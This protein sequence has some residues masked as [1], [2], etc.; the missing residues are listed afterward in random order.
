VRAI[1]LRRHGGPD[2]LVAETV[3][4]PVPGQGEA[5][6]RVR[7]VAVNRLD[8]LVRE[9]TGHAYRARLPLVPGYDVAGDIVA[10]GAGGAPV[11]SGDRVYVH[12]DYACGRCAACFA[13]DESLCPEYGL[14]GVDHDGGYAELVLAPVANLFALPDGLDH[15]TAAAGGSVSLT[16]HHMLFARGGLQAGETVLV[17]AS[18]S[19]VG[20]A[21][22]QLA[23]W[24]GARVLAT[25][26]SEAKRRSALAA[27]AEAAIDYGTPGWSD[28]VRAATGGRGADLVIDHTGADY[29]E[30]VVRALAPRGRV[31]VCGATSG[32]AAGVDL[33]D[34]FARQISIIGSSDGT[35]AELLAVLELLA[36]GVLRPAI[37][38][39]L[40]LEAAA[41]AQR[42]LAARDHDGRILLIPAP[43]RA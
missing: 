40:P 20:G 31:V 25:A 15:E 32:A 2:A 22:L 11:R 21:A 16:A 37:D 34:L 14:M 5:V 4:D 13:G 41:D 17:M 28:A 33:V 1:V 24:A 9:D 39:R 26:G 23:R 36:A 43:A 29:F 18:G 10:V 7:A 19:G 38:S 42:R 3:P 8:C 6:V 30:E 12:Y 27:G 35:R